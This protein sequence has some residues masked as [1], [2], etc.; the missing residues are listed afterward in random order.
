MMKNIG[1]EQM[2]NRV[3]SDKQL[4]NQQNPI[5][6][7]GS[8]SSVWKSAGLWTPR[9]RVQIPAGAPLNNKAEI[10]VVIA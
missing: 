10:L 2:K 4:K 3:R 7:G 9:S 6:I 8:G 1:T 5:L